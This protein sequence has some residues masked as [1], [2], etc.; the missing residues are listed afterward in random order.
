MAWTT[1]TR[2]IKGRRDVV[3]ANEEDMKERGLKHGDLVDIT[4]A[5]DPSK[6]RAGRTLLGQTIVAHTI[7]RGSVAAYYPEANNL[8]HACGSRPEERHA[9][10][11]IGGW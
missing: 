9:V 10:L 8:D 1:A 11:Q 2:G 5:G 3:F 7:S 4:T 6:G